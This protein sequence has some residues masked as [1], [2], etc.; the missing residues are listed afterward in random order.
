[1]PTIGVLS[2]VP[3]YVPVIEPIAGGAP[4]S[5]GESVKDIMPLPRQLVGESALFAIKVM[6]DSMINAAIT[7][8]DWVVVQPGS[9]ARDGDVV[10]ADIDGAPTVRTL[11]RTEGRVWLLP[12]HPS[13]ALTDGDKV[14]ILGRVVSVLRKL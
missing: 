3:V 11:R 12:H 7:D 14:S 2:H 8:G 4:M 1:M 9:E 6:G 13:Y 10:V 5:P